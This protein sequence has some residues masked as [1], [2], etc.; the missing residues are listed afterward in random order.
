MIE[1]E[2]A[3]DLVWTWFLE[4][5]LRVRSVTLDE[6]SCIV[7]KGGAEV[8]LATK[9]HPGSDLAILVSLGAACRR[10]KEFKLFGRV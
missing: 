3:C 1:H 7:I 6:R 8:E 10:R 5:D 9:L 2:L 4:G